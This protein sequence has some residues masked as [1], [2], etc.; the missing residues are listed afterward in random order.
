LICTWGGGIVG[1]DKE[2]RGLALR[3]CGE[4]DCDHRTWTICFFGRAVLCGDA[5]FE[6]ALFFLS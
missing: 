4:R 2:E 3:A 1:D 5:C 6:N